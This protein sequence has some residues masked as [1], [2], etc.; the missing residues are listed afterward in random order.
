MKKYNLLG[1][2]LVL[3]LVVC[4]FLP[5]DMILNTNPNSTE[6]LVLLDEE[7]AKIVVD[8]IEDVSIKTNLFE[9]GIA[10]FLI[11]PNFK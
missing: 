10:S 3:T 4:F 6:N 11:G 9:D 2:F 1:L 8:S 5:W 7:V